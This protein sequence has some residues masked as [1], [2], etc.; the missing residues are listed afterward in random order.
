[1]ALHSFSNASASNMKAS[2][3]ADISS[4]AAPWLSAAFPRE[5]KGSLHN[6]SKC[7][8]VLSVHAALA[9]WPASLPRAGTSAEGPFL[10][11]TPGRGSDA[12]TSRRESGSWSQNGA[13]VRRLEKSYGANVRG[14]DAAAVTRAEARAVDAPVYDPAVLTERFKRQPFKASFK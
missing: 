3:L 8:A 13:A 4:A 6:L 9:E 7:P 5:P 2:R 14:E 10:L 11:S 1:M 12:L